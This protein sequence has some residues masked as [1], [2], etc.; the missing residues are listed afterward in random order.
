M[1]YRFYQYLARGTAASTSRTGSS[2]T[3]PRAAPGH[4]DIIHDVYG[5]YYRFKNLHFRKSGLRF[6]EVIWSPRVAPGHRGAASCHV[7]LCHAVF[8]Y[9]AANL[10][11]KIL[12]FRGLDSRIVLISRGGILVSIGR[13]PEIMC[14]QILAGIILGRLGVRNAMLCSNAEHKHINKQQQTINTKG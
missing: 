8:R 1:L 6:R 13:C 5:F 9:F 11:I 14:Q 12:D 3:S 4:R 7:E 2:A 10:R